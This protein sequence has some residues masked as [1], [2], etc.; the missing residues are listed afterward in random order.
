MKSIKLS[1]SFQFKKNLKNLKNPYAPESYNLSKFLKNLLELKEHVIKK[2]IVDK[3]MSSL[4]NIKVIFV[5][6]IITRKTLLLKVI[7]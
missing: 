7:N 4:K 2:R 5:N 1:Q 6:N 3:V